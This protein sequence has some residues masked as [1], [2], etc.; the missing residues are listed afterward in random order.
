M[1]RK[2][3]IEEKDEESAVGSMPEPG[4]ARDA[5]VVAEGMGLYDK[6]DDS[7]EEV[8]VAKQIEEDEKAIRK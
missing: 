5:E 3:T 6:E 1:T 4:S 2:K 7:V 8:D